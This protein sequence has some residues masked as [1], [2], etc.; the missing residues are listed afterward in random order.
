MC[1]FMGQFAKAIRYA[2]IVPNRDVVV[3][4]ATFELGHP[5]YYV[6]II[7]DKTEDSF[8]FRYFAVLCPSQDYGNHPVADGGSG[9]RFSPVGLSFVKTGQMRQERE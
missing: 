6:G 4:T 2:D 5:N 7:E 9:I 1:K 8:W 3:F